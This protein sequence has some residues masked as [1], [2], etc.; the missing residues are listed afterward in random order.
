MQGS[1]WILGICCDYNEHS[2]QDRI[3]VVLRNTRLESGA[4]T[5]GPHIPIPKSLNLTTLENTGAMTVTSMILLGCLKGQ[6][7]PK[8]LFLNCKPEHPKLLRWILKI[9]HDPK[10]PIPW[11]FW[12]Y[13]ILRSC[14]IFSINS[15]PLSWGPEVNAVEQPT[16]LRNR[17]PVQRNVCQHILGFRGLGFRGVCLW[18]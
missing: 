18:G 6:G 3:R 7:L 9:L 13:S 1:P 15:R 16:G 10:S 17:A 14:R 12:Y 11:E 5:P 8:L 2:V 4:L